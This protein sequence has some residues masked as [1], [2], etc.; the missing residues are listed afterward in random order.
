VRYEKHWIEAVID[1]LTVND[2][3]RLRIS[4]GVE[5]A[6]H[7]TK[8]RIIIL[9]IDTA[10]KNTSKKELERGIGETVYTTHGACPN[11]P[12][13]VFEPLEPRMFSFNSPFGA[14]PECHGLG[15]ICRFPRI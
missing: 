7:Q 11:H 9:D 10:S 13:I 4:E 6:L 8:G 14:C 15:E 1:T 3:E 5:Q 2:D 12:E